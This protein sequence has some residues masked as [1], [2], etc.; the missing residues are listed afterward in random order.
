VKKI[1]LIL[2]SSAIVLAVVGAFA[3]RENK[4]LCS[5]LPQYHFDGT[6]YVPAGKAGVDYIC[7]TSH[8]TCTFIGESGSFTPCVLGTYTPS[9]NKDQ[10]PRK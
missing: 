7:E 3:L 1:K 9:P 6:N 5:E 4:P 8:D 2:I 10:A